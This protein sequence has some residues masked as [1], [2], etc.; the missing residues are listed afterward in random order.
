M[1]TMKTKDTSAALQLPSL[2]ILCL[3]VWFWAVEDFLE[4]VQM[5]LEI[6]REVVEFFKYPHCEDVIPGAGGYPVW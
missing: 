6:I 3:P 1:L 2:E 5:V 4:S